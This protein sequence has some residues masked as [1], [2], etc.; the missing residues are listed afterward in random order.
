LGIKSKTEKNK[1]NLESC[2]FLK[3][4]KSTLDFSTKEEAQAWAEKLVGEIIYQSRPA[5]EIKREDINHI[6]QNQFNIFDLPTSNDIGSGYIVCGFILEKRIA[7]PYESNLAKESWLPF[8]RLV[9]NK[10][11]FVPSSNFHCFKIAQLDFV[12][13]Q[14]IK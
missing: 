2:K 9:G 1:A 8:L 14:D 13:K 6:M 7:D 3:N 5:F 11:I 4:C 12:E 10:K